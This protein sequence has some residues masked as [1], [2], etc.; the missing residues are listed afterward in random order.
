MS[1][2]ARRQLQQMQLILTS[3]IFDGN[4]QEFKTLVRFLI[5]FHLMPA[6]FNNTFRNQVA[7]T[8]EEMSAF[9]HIVFL[10]F[11]EVYMYS[12]LFCLVRV[13]TQHNTTHQFTCSVFLRGFRGQI[14][15]VSIIE[16]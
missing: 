2:F 5:F 16:N 4:N 6:K 10:L 13:A 15:E 9:L 11:L 3:S 14:R 7:A 12:D 1:T 8:R